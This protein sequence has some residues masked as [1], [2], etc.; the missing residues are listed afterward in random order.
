MDLGLLLRSKDQAPSMIVTFLTKIQVLL[1]NTVRIVRTD[2]GTEFKNQT[3]HSY[4][5][6][7]GIE[8]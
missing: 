3:L 1:R 2:N 4:F 6:K 8:H 5:E 7:V